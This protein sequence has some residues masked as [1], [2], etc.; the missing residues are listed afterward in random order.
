MHYTH[1]REGESVMNRS[2]MV[3]MNDLQ[4]FHIWI[5]SL[6]HYWTQ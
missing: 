2:V 5:R 1:M 6:M 3:I 4:K